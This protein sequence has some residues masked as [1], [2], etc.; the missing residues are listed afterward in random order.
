MRITEAT[1]E[2]LV[3]LCAK[4]DRSQSYMVSRLIDEAY[5][6]IEQV[7]IAEHHESL[8]TAG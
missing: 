6:A 4:D 8:S 5:R 3:A 7:E 2:K 1:K